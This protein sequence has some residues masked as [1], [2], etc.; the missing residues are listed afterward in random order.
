MGPLTNPL[1]AA[2]LRRIRRSDISAGVIGLG[3]VGLPLAVELA[4]A[5]YSVV[6][7]DIDDRKV[8]AIE[9]GTSYIPDVRDAH[10][11]ELVTADR[12][13]A[14]SD[15]AALARLDTVNI[16]VPTPLRK[17]KDPDV[18]YMVA[19]VEQVAKY[20]HPKRD[21]DDVRESPALDVMQLLRDK[22]AEL[23]YS[24]PHVPFLTAEMWNGPHA[25][26]SLTLDREA[27]EACDCAVIITDHRAF[28]Y[29]LIANH[30]QS[31]VDTRNAL[32]GTV[33]SHAVR[34]GAPME[35]PSL[36]TAAA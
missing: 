19:A 35:L 14:T 4:R 31:V 13:H 29:E 27:L 8:E 12:L 28:D 2:L 6:G 7:L 25:L 36:S 21:I 32:R 11:A 17:T 23:V 34:L 10:L 20:L 18:S 16:C 24:D 5:G 26:E 9:R 1:A 33:A 3:Y 30:S 22:G 15:F